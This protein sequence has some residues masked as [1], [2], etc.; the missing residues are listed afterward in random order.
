MSNVLLGIP[1][2]KLSPK[3]EEQCAQQGDHEALVMHN[4]REAFYYV[5]GCY[6][7]RGSPLDDGALLSACYEGLKAAAPRFRPGMNR[8]FAYAKAD[9]RG[10]VI[11]TFHDL[12]IVKKVR[13]TEELPDPEQTFDDSHDAHDTPA[14]PTLAKKM[15]EVIALPEFELICLR[16]DWAEI[17][18]L[19]RTVLNDKERMILELHFQGSLNLQQIANMLATSRSDVHHT[20]QVALKKI[21]HQLINQKKFYDRR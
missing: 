11:K 21:R 16:E 14:I 12:D 8:F 3:A 20:K 17:A 9:V 5:K 10:A 18:P 7:K 4:L 6:Q 15:P 2:E 1:E 13:V 19:L